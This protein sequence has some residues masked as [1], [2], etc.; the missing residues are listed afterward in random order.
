MS[1]AIRELY[2]RGKELFESGNYIEAEGL[3]RE[4]IALRPNYADVF[5]KLGVIANLNS[6]L[7]EAVG[8]FEQALRLNPA[9]TEASMNLSITLNELGQ[10]E[11]AH[12]VLLESTRA[13]PRRM[14]D[15]RCALTDHFVAG[16]LANEHYKLGRLYI[17]ND[18]IDEA[19]EEFTKAVHLRPGLP[20]VHTRLGMAFRD[21]GNKAQAVESFQKAKAANSAYSPAYIQLGISYYT[22]GRYAE[23]RNEWNNA[24]EL[25]P[26]DREARSLLNLLKDK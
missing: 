25:N 7:D 21:R 5:N 17:E 6:A 8:F 26:S 23:A 14:G 1:D 9:Y 12:E 10:I 11:R 24:L 18:L 16:K 4:V 15:G 19:I 13:K 20:D 22:E 3:L 2:D